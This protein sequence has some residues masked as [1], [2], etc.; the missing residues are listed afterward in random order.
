MKN[1]K[2]LN[3]TTTRN[4]GMAHKLQTLIYKMVQVVRKTVDLLKYSVRS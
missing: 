2:N 4:L 1:K 3:K